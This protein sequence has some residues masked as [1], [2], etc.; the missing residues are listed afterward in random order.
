MKLS[1]IIPAYKAQKNISRCLESIFTGDN[2]F[3]DYEVIIVSDDEIDQE[4]EKLNRI[5]DSITRKHRKTARCLRNAR[6]KG[7]SGAR[8][9]GLDVA[10]GEYIWFVDSDDTVRA[11]WQRFF[12]NEVL[13]NCADL[14]VA[15]YVVLQNGKCEN[16][17]SM[18]DYCLLEID[19]FL[20][21]YFQSLQMKWMINPVWNKIFRKERIETI[22]FQE[23]YSMGEDL[24]FVLSVLKASKRVC[25]SLNSIYNY[26]LGENDNSLCSSFHKD[27]IYMT[28]MTWQLEREL[29]DVHNVR[30]QPDICNF[31]AENKYAYEIDL[32]TEYKGSWSDF[33]FIENKA[34][35][36]RF[37][38]SLDKKVDLIKQFSYF[39]Y[40]RLRKILSRI[41]HGRKME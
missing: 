5:I 22:R 36:I 1:I 8:N 31:F 37:P 19:V 34:A 29:L 18:K 14:I 16:E 20:S 2:G 40:V 21:S 10:N 3:T 4:W 17:H 15:G 32:F 38:E 6:A 41:K 12:E 33:I 11:N 27:A 9:T 25:L 23:G 30:I 7:V 39:R 24:L 13:T 26:H 28:F 35:E